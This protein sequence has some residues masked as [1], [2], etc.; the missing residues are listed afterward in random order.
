MLSY[1]RLSLLS[2]SFAQDILLK[3]CIYF[4]FRHS[5]DTLNTLLCP[6]FHCL[7]NLFAC[8]FMYIYVVPESTTLCTIIHFCYSGNVLHKLQK[9]LTQLF[10][11]CSAY[12]LPPA[13]T[14]SLTKSVL[15][16]ID[17][18]NTFWIQEWKTMNLYCTKLLSLHHIAN[19]GKQLKEKSRSLSTARV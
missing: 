11:I 3:L 1:S 9:K 17:R 7:I 12:P 6:T 8:K 15:K 4:S 18:Q 13:P 16:K 14:K 10:Q 5:I 19:W 2:H